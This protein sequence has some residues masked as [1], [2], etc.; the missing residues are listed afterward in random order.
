MS[1]GSIGC[2]VG[3]YEDVPVECATG[4]WGRTKFKSL[5]FLCSL[6]GVC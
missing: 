6:L 5:C 1:T 4:E 2:E 3:L